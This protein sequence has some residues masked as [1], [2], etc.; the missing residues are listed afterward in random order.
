MWSSACGRASGSGGSTCYR[1][2][3]GLGIQEKET[4]MLFRA[5]RGGWLLRAAA[6]ALPALTLACA[7]GARAPAGTPVADPEA[8]AAELRR[9]SLPAGPRQVTFAWT[10]DEAGSRLRGRGVARL[11]APERVRLDLFGP[12]GETYLS[13]A[14]VGDEFRLPEAAAG[15]VTLP[16][17]ALLWA[18]VGVVQPPAEARL[19]SATATER[20]LIVRYATEDG[21]S[22]EYR[23][24][25]EPLRLTSVTH[26]ARNR[27]TET[28]NLSWSAEGQLESTRYRDV[29]AFRELLLTMEGVVEVVSF[30]PGIWRLDAG[31]R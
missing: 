22:F 28:M 16:S 4:R 18:A 1:R 23:A 17:P 29:V 20:E 7:P 6:F 26:A 9:A 30:P 13:A 21:E 15:T 12:R 27:V 2:R 3:P 10:L 19:A 25:G 11:V 8:A 24:T 14:L 5:I 31:A